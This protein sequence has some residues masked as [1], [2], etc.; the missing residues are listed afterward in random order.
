MI[1][2]NF[3]LILMQEGVAPSDY[4][5]SVYETFLHEVLHKYSH[6]NNLGW[7]AGVHSEWNFNFPE[8]IEQFIEDMKAHGIDLEINDTTND[9]P[10]S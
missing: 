7:G 3:D 4:L 6:T 9:T 10:C 1:T 8:V 2:I 5:P